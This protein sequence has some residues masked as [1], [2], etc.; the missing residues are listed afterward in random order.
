[1][2]TVLIIDDETDVTA[3][4]KRKLESLGFQA[5]T[6]KEGQEALSLL[7]SCK[8]DLIVLDVQMPGMNGYT[9]LTELRKHPNSN[10][11][12]TPVIV[13]TAYAQNNPIFARHGIKAY[14]LKPLKLEDLADKVQEFLG[15]PKSEN[16]L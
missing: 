9:F 2:K 1:M 4:A 13:V 15:A 7:D 8:I 11:A 16:R 10:I 12:A 14:L 5:L 3:I 6:A